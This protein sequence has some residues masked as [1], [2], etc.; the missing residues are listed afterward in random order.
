M[1]EYFMDDRALVLEHTLISLKCSG[2]RFTVPSVFGNC[3]VTAAG[4]GALQLDNVQD[5]AFMPGYVELKDRCIGYSTTLQRMT[6]PE[7]VQSVSSELFVRSFYGFDPVISMDR[8]MPPAVF[9]DVLQAM[10]PADGDRCVLPSS[11]MKRDEMEPLRNLL[12]NA[13]PPPAE[14][15]REMRVL[16]EGRMPDGPANL[17]YS[18]TVFD[19]RPCYDFVCG[20]KETE[21]YTAVM[22]MIRDDDPGWRDPA[23]EKAADLAVRAGKPLVVPNVCPKVG[24]AV[25]GRVPGEAGPDGLFRL[26]FRLFKRH[27]FFPAV[28]HIR[29]QGSDWWIYSRNFLTSRPECPYL[30]EDVGVFDRS[31]LVTNRRTSEDVYAKYRFLALL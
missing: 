27:L 7:T 30:R 6:V 14:I 5:L 18:G 10:L 21:E 31:G 16:F 17:C 13:A 11:V 2:P 19:P 15:T 1:E 26:Q 3:T 9:R 29:H 28:R 4:S 20:R 22:E 12:C 25:C 24:M 23:A 8:A